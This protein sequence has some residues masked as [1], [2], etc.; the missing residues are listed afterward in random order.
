MANKRDRGGGRKWGN[1]CRKLICPRRR[2]DECIKQEIISRPRSSCSLSVII[3]SFARVEV[4]CCLRRV[5]CLSSHVCTLSLSREE[6]KR[7]S[8]RFKVHAKKS[9]ETIFCQSVYCV[10]ITYSLSHCVPWFN[11][12]CV[13]L[14]FPLV[15]WLFLF[16]GRFCVPGDLSFCYLA[17][18][19]CSHSIATFCVNTIWS[20]II[21]VG[22]RRWRRDALV[23]ILL[24]V[25]RAMDGSAP[26]SHWGN[27]G[28]RQR[29]GLG[30]Y[31]WSWSMGND[32]KWIYYYH[33]HV[34]SCSPSF[35]R[36]IPL[37]CTAS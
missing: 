25:T 5:F 3:L 29:S 17:T 6:I 37:F 23:V 16:G 13:L 30:L 26:E 11:Y 27:S 33:H 7:F 19:K 21:T 15:L 31:S 36:D 22:N 14:H 28:A 9:R 32:A 18:R 4:Y 2:K 20:F 10:A 35:T 1:Y 34:P 24:V 12:K 8:E